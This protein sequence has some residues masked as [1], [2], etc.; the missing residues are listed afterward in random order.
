MPKKVGI[1]RSLKPMNVEDLTAMVRAFGPT[2]LLFERMVRNYRKERGWARE[3][4]K[5]QTK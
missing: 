1:R 2:K 3:A 5:K 4:K